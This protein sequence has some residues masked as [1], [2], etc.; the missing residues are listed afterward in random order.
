MCF[1]GLSLQRDLVVV[2]LKEILSKHPSIK[3]A[4][5][6]G[7]YA[8]GCAK[9]LSDLDIAVLTENLGVILDISAEISRAL[10]IDEDRVS[11]VDMKFLDPLLILKIIEEGVEIVNRGVS[12]QK[13]IPHKVIEVREVER[14]ITESWLHGNSLDAEVLRDVVA[15]IRGD[16][17]DLEEILG[18]GF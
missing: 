18:M 17:D 16:A 8:R 1:R 7:S 5:V 2:K 3:L 6:F 13:L 11:I 10:N 15:R 14:G 4:Y 9:P 12:L